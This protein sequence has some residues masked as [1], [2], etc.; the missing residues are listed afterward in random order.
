MFQYE[1]NVSGGDSL[2]FKMETHSTYILKNHSMVSNVS[3]Q[4]CHFPECNLAYISHLRSS[5]I[6]SPAVDIDINEQYIQ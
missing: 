4:F 5:L 1:T 2:S 3:L 6:L